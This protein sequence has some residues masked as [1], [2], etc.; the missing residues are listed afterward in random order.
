M[1]CCGAGPYRGILSACGIV[2]GYK[3]CEDVSEFVFFDYAH[4]TERAYKQFAKLIWSGSD[5]FTMPYNLKTL[6]NL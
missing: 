1:A 5:I 2:K 6:V 3:V 4:P